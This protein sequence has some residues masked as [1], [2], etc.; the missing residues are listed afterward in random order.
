MQSAAG[1]LGNEMGRCNVC[2]VGI[3]PKGIT[4]QNEKLFRRLDPDD[5]AQRV[6]DTFSSIKTEMKKIMAPLGRSQ[7]LPIGMSDALGIDDADAAKRLG[8]KYAC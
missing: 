8:I 7:S 6:A 5:V 3:C 4:S 2:N 1:C